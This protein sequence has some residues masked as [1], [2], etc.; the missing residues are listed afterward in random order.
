MLSCSAT[1]QLEKMKDATRMIARGYAD[2]DRGYKNL[3]RIAFGK[4]LT[5]SS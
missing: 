3:S 5:T 2:I 1:F 4:F